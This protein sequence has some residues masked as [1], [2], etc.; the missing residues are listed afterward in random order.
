FVFEVR[1]NRPRRLAGQLSGAVRHTNV[2]RASNCIAEIRP[3]SS[4]ACKAPVSHRLNI[5]MRMATPSVALRQRAGRARTAGKL[6]EVAAAKSFPLAL[7][8]P[9]SDLAR[10]LRLGQITGR[11]HQHL[12]RATTMRWIIAISLAL[13]AVG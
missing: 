5:L 11:R 10:C 6:P 8:M 2:Q 13:A 12:S 7:R 3:L 1:R 9:A 4:P